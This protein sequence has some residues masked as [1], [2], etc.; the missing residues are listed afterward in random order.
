MEK[1]KPNIARAMKFYREK[2]KMTQGDIMRATG[3]E[4]SYVSRLESGGIKEPTITTMIL[5]A[6]A[7]GVDP[8]DFLKKAMSLGTI[9]K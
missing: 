8:C 2:K 7:L 6:R 4:R 1:V 9:E 3:L 5:V